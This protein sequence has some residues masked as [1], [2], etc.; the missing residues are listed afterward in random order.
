MGPLG[1]SLTRPNTSMDNAGPSSTIA[2]TNAVSPRAITHSQF[3]DW[4]Y[5]LNSLRDFQTSWSR[6]TPNIIA[7]DSVAMIENSLKNPIQIAPPGCKRFAR[8]GRVGVPSWCRPGRY[9]VVLLTAHQWT[10]DG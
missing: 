8:A 1:D 6:L 9:L 2:M 10:V 3:A 5:L 7:I 4:Q